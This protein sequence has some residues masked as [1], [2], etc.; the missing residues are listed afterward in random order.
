MMGNQ[1]ISNIFRA[2]V[3]IFLIELYNKMDE[4]RKM[5]FLESISTIGIFGSLIG[6]GWR[7]CSCFNS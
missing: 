4:L 5:S 1:E 7:N 6:W 2:L 3:I